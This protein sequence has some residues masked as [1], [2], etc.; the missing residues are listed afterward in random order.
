VLATL[1][2]TAGLDARVGPFVA[3][4]VL[5]LAI[6]GPI[7]ATQSKYVGNWMPRWFFSKDQPADGEKEAVPSA[8]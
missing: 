4:Y 5:V 7:L 6:A 8:A 3:L 1:A 2:A